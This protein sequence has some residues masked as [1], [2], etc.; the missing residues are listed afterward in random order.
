MILSH[1][2][3]FMEQKIDVWSTEEWDVKNV[4]CGKG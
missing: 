2:H 3:R 4:G 1:F